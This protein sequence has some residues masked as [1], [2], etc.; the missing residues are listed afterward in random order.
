MEFPV[1][2]FFPKQK[3]FGA[4]TLHIL[5]TRDRQL[6]GLRLPG[7]GEKGTSLDF[8]STD[9]PITISKVVGN[10]FFIL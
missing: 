3:Q 9:S 10:I 4:G 5:L 1:S 6:F 7:C 2:V 8:L